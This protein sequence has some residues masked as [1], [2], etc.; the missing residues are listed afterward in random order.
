MQYKLVHFNNGNLADSWQNHFKN[1]P[2][3][4]IINGDI[5]SVECDAIVSPA[6]SFGFMDGG[7]DLALSEKFGRNLEMR[8][9]K[10][11]MRRPLGEL[12]VGEALVESTENLDVPWLIVAPTMRVPMKLRQ[13][14]NA[15]LAMKAI[16]LAVKNK[17]MEPEINVVAIPGLGTGVGALTPEV[18]AQQM[19]QGF[20]DVELDESS[21]PVGFGAAQKNHVMLNPQE[22]RI[23]D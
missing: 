1:Q 20:Q 6:N 8:V 17:D 12:L 10:A 3:V 11:I 23:W 9:Q 16:L 2:N 19:W 13:S 14:V 4:E 21:Y 18:A 5:C 22:I 7:L 15:Y